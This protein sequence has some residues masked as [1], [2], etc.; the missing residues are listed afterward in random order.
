MSENRISE[1]IAE[2]FIHVA[3]PAGLLL[4]NEPAQGIATVGEPRGK[5]AKFASFEF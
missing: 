4:R 1:Q 3:V 5:L 2:D